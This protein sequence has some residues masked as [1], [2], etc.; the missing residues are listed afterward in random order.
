MPGTLVTDANA[1]NL[2]AGATLNA[3]GTTTSTVVQLDRP[4]EVIFRLVQGVV[5]GTSP[6]IRITVQGSDDSSFATFVT[7][8][9][10]GA[11]GTQATA[12]VSKQL[13][14]S[15]Y[16]K[17][18]RLSVVVGG[19]SPVYTGSTVYCQPENYLRTRTVTAD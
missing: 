6:T 9:T 7:Y 8:G 12:G 19:T 16:L 18:V 17:Y 13:T 5:T 1:A 10:F 4:D 2:L 15:A 11:S 3:A 14:A